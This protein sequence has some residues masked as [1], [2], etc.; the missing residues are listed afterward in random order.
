VLFK[1]SYAR[2]AGLSFAA[3]KSALAAARPF[4]I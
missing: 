4:A 1:A 3:L 2:G